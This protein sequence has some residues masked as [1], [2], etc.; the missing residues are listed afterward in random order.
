MLYGVYLS[1]PDLLYLGRES[2]V[3]YMFL[4]MALLF[5]IAE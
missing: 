1:L 4:Q 5:F 3:V 2:L